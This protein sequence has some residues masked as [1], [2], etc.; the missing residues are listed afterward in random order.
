[1]WDGE[2]GCGRDVAGWEV[3]CDRDVAGWGDG[4]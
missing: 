1:M 4:I 3:G 2:L